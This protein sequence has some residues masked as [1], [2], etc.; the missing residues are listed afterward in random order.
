MNQKRIKNVII[1]AVSIV[2]V[3]VVGYFTFVQKS[4]PIVQQVTPTTTPKDETTNWQTFTNTKHG[5]SFRYPMDWKV[6]SFVNTK[7]PMEV[8][9]VSDPKVKRPLEVSGYFTPVY[10]DVIIRN[11]DVSLDDW[12]KSNFDAGYSNIE[13]TTFADV[14]AY[15]AVAGGTTYSDEIYFK[16]TGQLYILS[17]NDVHI[18]DDEKVKATVA[19]IANSFR[20]IQ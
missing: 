2:L 12:A 7:N 9:S 17:M 19:A 5:F 6:S 16:K 18:G 10:L 20:F 14:P 11:V 1:I 4:I 3:G 15:R 8:F 13:K